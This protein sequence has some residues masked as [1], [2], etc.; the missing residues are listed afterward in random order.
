MGNQ[1]AAIE[2]ARLGRDERE[3]CENSGRKENLRRQNQIGKIK[4]GNKPIG[5]G[6]DA[7]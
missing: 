6:G 2:G 3:P 4:G 7:K 1:K 5:I